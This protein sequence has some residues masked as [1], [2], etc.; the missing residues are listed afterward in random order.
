MR[1]ILLG[2]AALCVSAGLIAPAAAETVIVRPAHRPVVVVERPPVVVV[3]PR[4]RHLVSVCRV[5]VHNGYRVRRCR[6][7]WRYY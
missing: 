6:N 3:H 5:S 1:K 4:R 7:E 2:V